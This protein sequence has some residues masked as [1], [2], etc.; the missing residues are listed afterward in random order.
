M[1][2][3]ENHPI[4][5]IVT[6]IVTIIPFHSRMIIL[7]THRRRRRRR[8]RHHHHHPYHCLNTNTTATGRIQSMRPN[9]NKLG[10]E[11]MHGLLVQMVK[12]I[13]FQ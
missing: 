9:S 2:S 12:N 3:T 13:L 4:A 5:V 8:R 7:H 1:G 6:V 10:A 11:S